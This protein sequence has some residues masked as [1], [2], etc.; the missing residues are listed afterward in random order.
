M[1]GDFKKRIDKY[2]KENHVSVDAALKAAA[3]K[4]KRPL[5]ECIK[6][7]KGDIIKSRRG[8]LK[9]GGGIA[10]LRETFSKTA[11]K[12]QK[13]ESLFT[14]MEA[15]IMTTLKKNEWLLEQD[16]K[17]S[18]GLNQVEFTMIKSSYA[19]LIIETKKD[20]K[21][22]NIWAHPDCVD[23]VFEAINS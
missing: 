20:G 16:V 6:R 21:H 3:Q 18:C 9:S 12:Q 8:G 22:Y 11:I 7:Y 15:F 10:K 17:E 2:A 23:A 4:D 19:H 13:L 5:K 14:T 1:K